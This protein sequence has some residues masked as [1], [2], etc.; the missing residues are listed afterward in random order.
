MD[1]KLILRRLT[2]CGTLLLATSGLFAADTTKPNI[3]ILFA[4]DKC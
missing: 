2:F 4:D 3:V 1:T